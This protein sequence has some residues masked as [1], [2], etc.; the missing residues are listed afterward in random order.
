MVKIYVKQIIAG[1]MTV[2]EVPSK[3]LE[4][5]TS[6]FDEMLENNEITEADYYRYMGIV[7]ND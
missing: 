5:V 6:V 2:S 3:W 4:E 7:Q 1:K